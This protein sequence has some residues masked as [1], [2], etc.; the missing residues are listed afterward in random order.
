MVTDAGN[1]GSSDGATMT[2]IHPAIAYE[3]G[4][5]PEPLDGAAGPVRFLRLLGD[6]QLSVYTRQSFVAGFL[7]ARLLFQNFVLINEPAF[8][9][10]ILVA[11]H[12]NYVKSRLAR[13]ILRP[14]LGNGLLISE[15]EFWRRQR[16]IMAPAF[17]SR[18]VARAAGVVVRRARQRVGQWRAASESGRSLD[19]SHEMMSLTMEIVA[20]ALFSSEIA[21][22]IDEL[23]RA[24]KTLIASLGT[25]NP[26]DV[27][28]FPNGSPGGARAAPAPRSPCSTGPSTTSSPPGAARRRRRVTC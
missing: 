22:S 12:Q 27:L 5:V 6:N 25:P 17:H 3:S 20:E 9:E 16:R 13:Q 24:I 1:G 14:V 26:L 18:Q 2:D 15:G 23:E 7:E 11:N 28:G 10:H 21:G 4:V 19:I 8:I